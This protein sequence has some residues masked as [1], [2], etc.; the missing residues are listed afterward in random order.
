MLK[1]KHGAEEE[2]PRGDTDVISVPE[3]C[4]VGRVGLVGRK[5]ERERE[6]VREKEK[7]ERERERKREGE[8]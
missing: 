3:T 7:G 5:R 6:R 2:V 4:R 8:R 1:Q